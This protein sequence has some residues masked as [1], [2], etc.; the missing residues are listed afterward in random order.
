MTST[1]GRQAPDAAV[2][3]YH[4]VHP[5]AF[6]R[7]SAGRADL[8]AFAATRAALRLAPGPVQIRHDHG[9][10]SAAADVE[11]P[12]SFHF[13]TDPHAAGAEDAAV[14]VQHVTLMGK[15]HR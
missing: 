1:P 4:L 11:N 10:D 6:L 14:V 8:H 9:A 3:F 7:Q 13:R 5:E 2:P 12:R 15:V